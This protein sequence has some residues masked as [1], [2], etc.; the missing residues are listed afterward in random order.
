MALTR[1]RTT[2]AAAAAK[3][4]DWSPP[5]SGTKL[6]FRWSRSWRRS[7]RAHPGSYF[8]WTKIRSVRAPG[9]TWQFHFRSIVGLFFF[10]CLQHN[11]LSQKSAGATG[12]FNCVFFFSSPPHWLFYGIGS[13]TARDCR[14]ASVGVSFP[15]IPPLISH[16]LLVVQLVATLPALSPRQT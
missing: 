2:A 7:R 6:A 5:P 11:L 16:H 12:R 1:M 8:S 3:G 9:K 4:S 10:F 13:V 15:H 14:R